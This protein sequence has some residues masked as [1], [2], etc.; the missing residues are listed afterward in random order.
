MSKLKFRF[1]VILVMIMVIYSCSQDK[2]TPE[3]PV[4]I[5]YDETGLIEANADHESRQMRYKLIQSKVSDRN[6]LLQTIQPQLEGFSKERFAA[7]TPM[8][9]ERSIQELQDHIQQGISPTKN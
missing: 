6:E 3:I 7:L 5:P 9:Y 2:S 1:A 8:I 4:W